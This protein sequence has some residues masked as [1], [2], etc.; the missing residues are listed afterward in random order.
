MTNARLVADLRRHRG[1]ANWIIEL[2]NSFASQKELTVGWLVRPDQESLVNQDQLF[3][4]AGP[5]DDTW[6]EKIN[7]HF[8]TITQ[9]GSTGPFWVL[10]YD[11][12]LRFWLIGLKIDQM[13]VL[14]PAQ[15]IAEDSRRRRQQSIQELRARVVSPSKEQQSITT[16]EGIE[17]AK[18]VLRRGGHSSEHT[19][20]NQAHLRAKM[21]EL[22]PRARRNP[23]D[24][25]S[26]A[27]ITNLVDAGLQEGWLKR[28][29]RVQ[30]R[31]GT[32]ALYLTEQIPLQIAA[33]VSIAEPESRPAEVSAPVSGII[34]Q[35]GVEL[36]AGVQ[37]KRKKHPNRASDFEAALSNLQIGGMPQ[38]RELLLDAV[39]SLLAD[40]TA[41]GNLTVVKLFSCA[42]KS[43]QAEAEVDGFI[44]EKNWPIAMKCTHRMMLRA[45][46]LVGEEEKPIVDQIGYTSRRVL[47][48]TPEFRKRCEAYLVEQIIAR[49]GGVNYD[50]ELYYLGL[51]LYRRG[52]GNAVTPED[53]K[54]KADEL[55][56]F[57]L[58]EGQISMGPD[59]IIRLAMP[60]TNESSPDLTIVPKLQKTVAAS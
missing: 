32:E 38:S 28:F 13:M 5:T 59:R 35:P 14:S 15:L 43:A 50:D 30:S 46:V 8:A 21:A 7:G 34:T 29:R 2:I 23:N 20:M 48:L 51:V 26:D 39:E 4:V 40:A 53:L 27:L 49:C 60:G 22:D 19:A 36:L 3:G 31:T 17:L 16:D 44:A 10:T 12:N 18:K 52:A 11:T 9:N 41:S 55:L 54:M 1:D 42:L 56:A 45:G 24:P 57:M 37:E 25:E 33:P 58:A 6:S 47:S